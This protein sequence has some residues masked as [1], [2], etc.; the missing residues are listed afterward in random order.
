MLK[1]INLVL[2][3][4]IHLKCTLRINVVKKGSTLI[5]VLKQINAFVSKKTFAKL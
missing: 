5:G 2:L 3:N 4:V 1:I